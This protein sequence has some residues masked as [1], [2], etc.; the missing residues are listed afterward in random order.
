MR[1]RLSHCSIRRSLKTVQRLHR[2]GS[3]VHSPCDP[4]HMNPSE[5]AGWPGTHSPCSPSPSRQVIS[6][7]KKAPWA[8]FSI[9]PPGRVD[10]PRTLFGRD[11]LR[12]D[13]R[14]WRSFRDL[15][16][17]AERQPQPQ[18]ASGCSGALPK[19]WKG[20]HA[21]WAMPRSNRLRH[22]APEQIFGGPKIRTAHATSVGRRVKPP[23]GAKSSRPA[24]A[25]VAGHLPAEVC[26]KRGMSGS[27][28]ASVSAFPL[29][30]KDRDS[31]RWIAA[32]RLA[33]PHPAAA[34][35][36][37]DS[38]GESARAGTPSGPPARADLSGRCTPR[39]SA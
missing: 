35:H 5:L 3:G 32:A 18:V 33:R 26:H 30:G 29:A 34:A 37:A 24:R 6:S 1:L 38:T 25:T 23:A 19:A 13:D 9:L 31:T 16:R 2:C 15:S 20:R 21:P 14:G 36:A 12:E 39:S 11:R 27:F 28:P 7:T 22:A 17:R 10:Q 4:R 8:P